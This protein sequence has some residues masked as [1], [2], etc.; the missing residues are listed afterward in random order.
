MVFFP[1][2]LFKFR[3][4]FFS[5]VFDI[6]LSDPLLEK[7]SRKDPADLTHLFPMHPFCTP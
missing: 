7:S 6:L 3:F 4:F 1:S 2:F 5:D